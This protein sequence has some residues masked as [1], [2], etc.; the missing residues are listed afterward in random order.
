M[1]HNTAA[2]SDI[3]CTDAQRAD[4]FA[5]ATP[6]HIAGTVFKHHRC[7]VALELPHHR[8]MGPT[9][10]RRLSESERVAP[11]PED[12]HEEAPILVLKPILSTS[13][14]VR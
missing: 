12:A 2:W 3:V 10:A 7:R 9:R 14:R 5:F 11:E 13:H 8:G 1:H 6:R 4:V